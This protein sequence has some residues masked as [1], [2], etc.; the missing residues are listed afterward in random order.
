[1]PL[2]EDIE[3]LMAALAARAATL[4]ET[5]APK[6][7]ALLGHSIAA[8]RGTAALQ[9]IIDAAEDGLADIATDKAEALADLL[10][11]KDA[12]TTTLTN[13]LVTLSA[14]LTA[15]KDGA[16]GEVQ[17][18]YLSVAGMRI[19][20]MAWRLFPNSNALPTPLLPLI[21]QELVAADYAELVAAWGLGG[22]GCEFVTR[23]NASNPY[24]ITVRVETNVLY[25]PNMNG[26]FPQGVALADMGKFFPDM[27]RTHT[28]DNHADGQFV[29]DAVGTTGA[30]TA[31]GAKKKVNA[32]GGITA[33]SLVSGGGTTVAGGK[34]KPEA[35]AGLFVVRAK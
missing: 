1:M 4:V 5:A 18:A 31:G 34:N 16:I 7:L 25:M 2:V 30:T 35:M 14:N 20:D 3:T 9:T 33:A 13:L 11:S 10:A 32:T 21:G 27:M 12:H 29:V 15:A 23:Y 6:D 8:M 19:G 24:G 17:S 26:L 22:A 28:H